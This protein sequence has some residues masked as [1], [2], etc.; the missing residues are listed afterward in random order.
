MNPLMDAALKYAKR[1][2]PVLPLHTPTGDGCS[3]GNPLCKKIGKHPRTPSGLSDATVDQE[4]IRRWWTKWPDANIGILTGA[5][6]GLIV[7][8][9]DNAGGKNGEQ[10]FAAMAQAHGGTPETLIAKTGSG[11][12]HLALK[13]PNVP[14]KNSVG[15]L[16]PGVDVRADGAY[17]VAAPS[18]HASGQ[19]Y[20]WLNEGHELADAPEWLLEQLQARKPENR[21]TV[22]STTSGDVIPEGTRN[23]TLFRIGCMLRGHLAMQ[24]EE[25]VKR[26][27][28]YN[29]AKCVPPLDEC[30]VLTIATSVCKYPPEQGKKSLSRQERNPLYWLKL[31]VRD[32]NA[33]LR[34]SSMADY[35]VGWYFK[36]RIF[37]WQNA[38]V[39][40]LDPS[41]L[42]RLAGAESKEAFERD[43]ALVL[44]EYQPATICGEEVLLN[45]KMA[46]EYAD[47]LELWISKKMAG[48]ASRDR[49]KADP[50]LGN[51]T[52]PR[53][54]ALVQ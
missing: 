3:C 35:Q 47:T 2:W 31:N 48:E 6:S 41:R 27:M 39:L 54:A 51:A 18:A 12:K 13:H 36:L 20:R 16:A 43:S 46:A 32:F 24:H 30:E 50:S 7:I 25:V 5:K 4:L 33:D 38:G 21:S 14:I 8:D 28:L 1:C 15:K 11:G 37:A 52:A 44:A 40:P 23:D 9:L 42:W 29:A 26:L 49:H 22:A 19:P 45:L 10:N 34:V 17:I 53:N